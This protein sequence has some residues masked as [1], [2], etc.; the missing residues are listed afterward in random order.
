MQVIDAI[1]TKLKT[2]V[3]DW[4]PISIMPLGD[5]QAGSPGTDWE[6][7]NK[8]VQWGVKHE[9]FWLGMGDYSD[10]LSPSNRR[11]LRNAGLYDTANQLIDEWHR[12]HLDQLKEV[13]APTRGMWMGIHQGHHYH[14][15]EDGGTTDTELARFLDAP[16]L[17]TAAV[18]RL[19][20]KD[21][22]HHV[23][24]CLIWSHHGEG[25]AQQNPFNR[26]FAVAP[27]FPQ[28][29]LFLQGHNTALG[30]RRL[31]RILF[32]GRP[33][34]LRMR[35]SDQVFVLTGGFMRGYQQGSTFAGRAQGSYVEKAM[36]RPTAIGGA[37]IT[38]TPRR[39]AEGRYS[40]V[41]I[42]VST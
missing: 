20:F 7:L 41:D 38:I 14:E 27:G 10:F 33:G 35:S 40:D 2:K 39:A 24:E 19:M 28:V 36:M 31:D 11:F 3:L 34:E 22:Q 12:K 15:F 18:S 17:G 13:L 42:F 29:N 16:F 23:A 30:A 21:T 37:L 9:V 6:R 1:P 25:G 5:I 4:A 26:L 32:Y 8:H